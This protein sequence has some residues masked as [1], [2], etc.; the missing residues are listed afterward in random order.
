MVAP[1][2]EFF[3]EPGPVAELEQLA[4]A[5]AAAVMA[6]AM[7]TAFLLVMTVSF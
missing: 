2:F 1:F 3:W 7:E 6:A 5:S 4:T